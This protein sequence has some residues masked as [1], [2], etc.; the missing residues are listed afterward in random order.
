MLFLAVWLAPSLV[1]S[2]ARA[3]EDDG[4]LWLTATAS[5]SLPQDWSAVLLV[6]A[7]VIDDV[8]DF[9]RLLVNPSI[10]RTLGAGFAAAFGYDAHVIRNPR[11]RLEHRT[12]QQLDYRHDLVSLPI[13][14][15]AR[16]EERY[17]E[18]E[19]G[20]ALRLR[21]LLGT[22]VP[23]VD[24]GWS[25]VLRNEL[26]IDLNGKREG[27]RH[28]GFGETRLFVGVDR[29]LGEN[30]GLEIGYQLQYV[31]RRGEDLAAHTLS[32]AVRFGD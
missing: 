30:A 14:H 16:L 10:G 11:V 5:K 4:V 9:E 15:R 20:A 29:P 2:L 19:D 25:G 28:A 12:W 21:Y 22:S 27:P 17:I 3:T 23:I 8:D 7:R 24:T 1:P 26:F 13:Q 6:Q 31:D 18:G 32:I